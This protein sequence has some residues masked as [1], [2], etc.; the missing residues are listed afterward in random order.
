MADASDFPYL[1][2]DLI[3]LLGILCHNRKAI[4]DRIRLCGGIPLVLNLCTIDDR[5][6]CKFPFGLH[7]LTCCCCF[8]PERHSLT[9]SLTHHRPL[10][11]TFQ[12]TMIMKILDLR[13]YAIFALRNLLHNN[14]ENQAVVNNFQADE[15]VGPNVVVRELPG[16]K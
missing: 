4:Q 10:R 5:N 16:A 8:S 15:H 13:E 11:F 14:P 12:L 7:W 9:L 3:R 2:R 6:P 1:K